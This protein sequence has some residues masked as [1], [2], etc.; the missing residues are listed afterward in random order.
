MPKFGVV[1]K[2]VP[3]ERSLDVCAP[4]FAIAVRAML[5]DLEG[6]RSEWAFE[7]LRTPE[8]QRF[9][10]GFGRDFDDGRGKVTNAQTSLYSWH[11]FGMAVDVVE[12]DATP[13]DAPVSFWNEIGEAAERNGLV[14]GGRWRKPDLPHV[15]WGKC[16]AS[17]DDHD[18]ALYA[19]GGLKAVWMKYGAL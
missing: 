18:R 12:K 8:R 10:Y 7:T 2:E 3:V 1:P 16:K 17:P 11:G 15:Q 6:G 5:K 9:L 14:W 19:S 4:K 13:W